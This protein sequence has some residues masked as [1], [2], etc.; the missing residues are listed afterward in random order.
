[1]AGRRGIGIGLYSGD[2]RSLVANN[3]LSSPIGIYL[4]GASDSTLTGNVVSRSYNGISVN[5]SNRVSV[6]NNL[7]RGATHDGIFVGDR[8]TDV[9]LH[10]NSA[11][12]NGDDGIDVES[13]NATVVGNEAN[14]NADLG[15]EAVEGVQDGGGNTAFGN[16]NPLQC[17]NVVCQ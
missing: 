5:V 12:R 2:Q 9:T 15:I 16:G 11:R 10:R 6:L 4:G 14:R 7:V 17:L 13:P 1:V 8:N 3:F